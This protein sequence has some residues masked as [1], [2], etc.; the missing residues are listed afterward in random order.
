[1]DTAFLVR[2]SISQWSAR[3]L[4]KEAT[5]QARERAGTDDKANVAVYKSVIAADVLDAIK[6]IASAARIEHEKRTVPWQYRGPGAIAAA[7]FAD[8]KKA[9]QQYEA[10]FYRAVDRFCAAYE[11]ERIEAKTYLKSLYNP[12]DYP[13]DVRE[14]FSFSVIAEP[15]PASSDFRVAGLSKEDSEAIERDIAKRRQAAIDNAQGVAWDRVRD[16]VTKLQSKAA[17]FKPATNNEKAQGVFRDSVVENLQELV[18]MLPSLNIKNDAK[19]AEIAATVETELCGYSAD[20]LRKS[21]AARRDVQAS[22]A[23]ILAQVQAIWA[24]RGGADNVRGESENNSDE[25]QSAA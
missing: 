7:G 5:R 20:T 23:D 1:M 25:V 16:L 4:D 22:A 15:M 12:A 14:R 10:D 17:N 13:D 19:L 8:Y 11:A 24:A 3:K 18:A 2:L 9:M 21:E 6:D